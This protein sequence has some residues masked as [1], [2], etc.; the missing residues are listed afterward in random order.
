MRLD[1]LVRA[2]TILTLDEDRPT[3]RAMGIIGGRVVGFDEELDGCTADRLEDFGDA[4]ITPGFIDAHCHTT[5]WGL[6]LSGLDLSPARGLEEL[7]ALLEAEMLRLEQQPG[8]WLNGTGF[9]HKN[10]GGLFPDIKRL[11][12]ITGGRPLYLR[13]VSGH[14]SITNTA[15]L[16]L[17]GALQPHFTDPVGGA[18]VRDA[19]GAPTGLVEEAAQG[20]IQK[21]LLPYSL[22][23]IVSALDAATARYAA[24]G[25]TSFTEAGVGGGWIGHSPVEVTAYQLALAAGKLRARAQLMPT[26]DALEVQSSHAA[27]AHGTGT[28]RGL[29]L[30]I[31]AGFGNEHLSLGPV[32][33][34]MDGSLLGATAAVTEDYCG[35]QHN[36]G[37]LLD[38]PQEYRER[39][40][41]AYRSGW[42]VALHAI[43]DAA[44]DL[45]IEI[46]SELQ[47]KHGPNALPNRIEH[48]GIARPD[49]VTSVAKHGIAVTPQASFIGPLGD[50]FAALVG[51]EREGWLYRGQSLLEAGVLVAGSSDLPVADNN[52]RRAMASAVDRLTEK[53][54]VL[55][56]AAE[57]LSPLEALRLY[58]V[59]AAKATGQFTDRGSLTRGKLADFV[60]L[61]ESPLT[62][63]DISALTIL[64]TFVGGKQSYAPLPV[65]ATA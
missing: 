14:A 29:D 22:E 53:G 51:P 40:A 24:E 7:Y 32:K 18:V 16:A 39:V 54:K 42:P 31:V 2:G 21:M 55:G 61:S 4:T 38:D 44:I 1:L 50:Q 36:T 3:A 64:G 46:I 12:A 28:G 57:C 10:H 59:N 45:A 30:G 20:I 56:G 17:A 34:F 19:N 62:T 6:G 35:H 58:T 37:Y 9:N 11:D 25:I 26:L 47:L 13:H 63:S 15:T 49:Q 48:F 5:W 52:V 65:A 27:D 41:G 33:V 43:G 8:V 23:Q 60:I